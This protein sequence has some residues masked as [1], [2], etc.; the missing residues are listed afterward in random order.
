MI[1][2]TRGVRLLFLFCCLLI[3]L[4]SVSVAQTLSSAHKLVDVKVAGKTRFAAEE[5]I[6]ASGLQLGMT[7]SD[8]DFKKAVRNLGD[9]GAFS[10]VGYKFSYSSA[11]TKLE[12][13]L[14]DNPRWLPVH[15]DDFV[16]FTDDEM[17]NWIK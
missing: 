17:R 16:W 9:T 4:C 1:A 6:I 8:E 13:Q 10:D 15:F 5:I 12:L 2:A 14:T 7:A 11:G 3:A